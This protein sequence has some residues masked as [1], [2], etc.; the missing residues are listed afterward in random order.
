MASIESVYTK[1]SWNATARFSDQYINMATLLTCDLMYLISYASMNISI[2]IFFT[3]RRSL[4]LV[5][6]MLYLLI[7]R[8]KALDRFSWD[9]LTIYC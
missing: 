1:D 5:R 6:M 9:Q 4:K 7:Y 2:R 8:V 3:R